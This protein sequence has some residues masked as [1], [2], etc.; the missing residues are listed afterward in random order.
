M[1]YQSNVFI[2]CPFDSDYQKLL[3][4]LLFTIRKAGLHPRI[5]LERFDSGEFRLDKINELLL[6][7]EYSIHDLSRIKSSSAVEY[8]RLNMPFELGIDLGC[9]L[10]HHNKKYRSKK[11]LILE[12]EKHSVQ[13]ALSDVSF[14]DCKCHYSKAEEI[15]HQV[16]N[17]FVECGLKNLIPGSK[18]WDDYNMFN[19]NLYP[20]KKKKGYSKR[21]IDRLPI[22]EFIQ[23][24]NEVI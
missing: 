20:R 5:A 3:K 18:I 4:P 2:N 23:F 22:P 11:F 10:Y 17:W 19:S 14:G 13:K 8:F 21:D 1:P 9:K 15:V 12:G 7:S 6:E 16:R 24:M